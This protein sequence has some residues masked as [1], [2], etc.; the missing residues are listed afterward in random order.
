MNGIAAKLD[1]LTFTEEGLRDTILKVAGNESYARNMKE[2][3]KLYRDQPM[4]PLD[5]AIW[6]VEYVIRNPNATHLRSPALDLNIFA[7]NS[8]DVLFL[9][10]FVI[11]VISFTLYQIALF[12][13]CKQRRQKLHEKKE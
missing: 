10:I 13:F 8:L 9:F 3:S 1:Y 5:R 4:K 6:W 2:R 11:F 12:C 7:V